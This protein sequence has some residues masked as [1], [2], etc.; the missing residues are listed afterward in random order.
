M[1]TLENIGFLRMVVL[2]KQ[3][4]YGQILVELE[5]NWN[6]CKILLGGDIG[7][8]LSQ[9]FSNDVEKTFRWQNFI[10]FI[11]FIVFLLLSLFF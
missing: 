11:V 6:D 5:E 3:P 7:F 8:K 10:I 4:L 2:S 9:I 1:H